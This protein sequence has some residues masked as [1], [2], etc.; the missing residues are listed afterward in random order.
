[1]PKNEDGE[2]ELILVNKQVLSVFLIFVILLG[3]F[4]TV[5]YRVLGDERTHITH[6]AHQLTNTAIPTVVRGGADI[7]LP[8]SAHIPGIID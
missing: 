3:V 6:Y 5:G 1:M 8:R 4:F 2:F 7:D